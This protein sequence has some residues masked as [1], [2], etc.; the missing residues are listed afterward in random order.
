MILSLRRESSN[1]YA[2]Q[3]GSFH[4]QYS[5]ARRTNDVIARYSTA[6]RN[7][8]DPTH[9]EPWVSPTIQKPEET[10]GREDERKATVEVSLH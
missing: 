1:L 4:A 7:L 8:M 6:W 3:V 9:L 2:G 10:G 5:P